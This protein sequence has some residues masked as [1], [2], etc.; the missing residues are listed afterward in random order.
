MCIGGWGNSKSVMRRSK[1]AE[2]T[3]TTPYYGAL[4]SSS[5]WRTFLLD[6][7]TNNALELYSV[8]DSG[9]KT[10]LMSSPRQSDT[11]DVTAVGFATGWGSTGKW[12][13]DVDEGV[14][15]SLCKRVRS[16]V[17]G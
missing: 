17:I 7:S 8:N 12:K 6:W 13:I 11:L 5:S 15:P 2:V 10:L 1:G 3:V 4:L 14:G 9:F 16:C